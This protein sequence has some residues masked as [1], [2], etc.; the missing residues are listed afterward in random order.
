MLVPSQGCPKGVC[1]PCF[2]MGEGF[3]LL[4]WQCAVSPLVDVGGTRRES[5]HYSQLAYLLVIAHTVVV[6]GTEGWFSEVP[7]VP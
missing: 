5:L 3:S 2:K 1:L 6:E 4:K 7:L